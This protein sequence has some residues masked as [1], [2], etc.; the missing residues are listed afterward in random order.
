[1]YEK[2]RTVD[3]TFETEVVFRTE[4]RQRLCLV[5][6]EIN[7]VQVVAVFVPFA[8]V[9]SGSGIDENIQT[10]NISLNYDLPF[11][12]WSVRRRKYEFNP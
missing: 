12:F 8:L 4:E 10:K 5:A 2:L 1:M 3:D 6:L 9:P 7:G 11:F